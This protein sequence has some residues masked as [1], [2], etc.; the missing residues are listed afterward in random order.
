MVN[1][2]NLAMKVGK[3]MVE[4][5]RLDMRAAWTIIAATGSGK[6]KKDFKQN[7]GNSNLDLALTLSCV[8]LVWIFNPSGLHFIHL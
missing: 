5:F 1:E 7:L 8:T 3:E 6:N 2:L 4:F